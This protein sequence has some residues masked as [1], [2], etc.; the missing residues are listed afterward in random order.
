MADDVQRQLLAF[1]EKTE[2][3]FEKAAED[4]N[5]RIEKLRGEMNVGLQSIREDMQH[6]LDNIERLLMDAVQSSA[7]AKACD[8]SRDE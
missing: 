2:D 5:E 8:L 7:S 3:A 4:N 1:Q 6:R